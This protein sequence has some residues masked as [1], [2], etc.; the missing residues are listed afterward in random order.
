MITILNKNKKFQLLIHP[1]ADP[2]RQKSISN[3]EIL[4]YYLLDVQFEDVYDLFQDPK[5]LNLTPSLSQSNGDPLP[6]FLTYHLANNS[7]TG[8]PGEDD[9]GLYNLD[10]KAT[11]NNSLFA[12]ITFRVIVK[13]KHF[14]II[15]LIFGDNLTVL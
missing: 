12:V 14:F 9:V 7:L 8:N 11:N 2:V 10:Y 5:S 15:I 13:S 1:S 4:N 3:I 6:A